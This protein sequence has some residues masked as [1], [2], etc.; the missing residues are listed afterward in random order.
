V[1][2]EVIPERAEDNQNS[3]VVSHALKN[4]IS[5]EGLEHVLGQNGS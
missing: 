5:Y 4:T 1:S 3:K 2:I